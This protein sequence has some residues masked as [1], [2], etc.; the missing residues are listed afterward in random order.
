MLINQ[1]LDCLANDARFVEVTRMEMAAAL[2]LDPV[3]MEEEAEVLREVPG[4]PEDM[5]TVRLTR[6]PLTK[7]QQV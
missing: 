4:S 2:C 5:R 1:G 6:D 7:E 3:E